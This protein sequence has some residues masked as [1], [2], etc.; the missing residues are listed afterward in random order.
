MAR[1]FIETQVGHERLEYC[2]MRRM[3]GWRRKFNELDTV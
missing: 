1:D 3:A 2:G